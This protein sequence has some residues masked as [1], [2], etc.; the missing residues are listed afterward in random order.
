MEHQKAVME[1][2][3]RK[4][5][6]DQ[7]FERHFKRAIKRDIES[8][9]SIFDTQTESGIVRRETLK[10]WNYGKENLHLG[11]DGGES[12]EQSNDREIQ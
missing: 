3:R 5:V 8:R 12:P 9:K 2:R 11:Q 4:L 10:N 7:K 6:P 1:S